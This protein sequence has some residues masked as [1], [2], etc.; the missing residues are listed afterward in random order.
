VSERYL[1]SPEEI[2]ALAEA[3]A[4]QAEGPAAAA[5]EPDDPGDDSPRPD[6]G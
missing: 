3:V 2:E 4:R 6:A 5:G 1:L